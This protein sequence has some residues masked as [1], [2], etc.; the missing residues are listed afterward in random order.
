[1]HVKYVFIIFVCLFNNI[2][3]SKTNKNIIYLSWE[4]VV[5]I[6]LKENLTLKSK[7]L[8]YE[9][10]GLE[11]WKAI[12]SFLPIFSYQGTFIRNLELP[13][14][15]FMG[16]QFVVGTNYSFQH[17]LDLTLPVF[18]GGMRWFNLS[19]QKSLK[20]S[21]SEELKGQKSQT[22]LAALQS[23][24]GIMLSNELMK[25]AKQAVNVA[26][27]NLE[28]VEKHY[29]LGAATELD[30]KRANA[31][32]YSTLP[33]LETATSTR[34]LSYQR[35]KTILNIPLED[36]LVITDSLESENFLE[37]YSSFSLDELKNLALEKRNDLLSLGHK[38]DATGEGEKMALAQF[39]PVIS[40]S[41]N[42]THQAQ[43]D[44]ANI[45]WND[46]IRSKSLI[47]SVY[48][49][50]F[51]GGKKIIDYQLAQ[52]KTEQMKMTLKQAK[53]LASLDI[54][55]KYYSF[56]EV[57]KS[58][59]SLKQAMEESKESMRI[60]SLMYGNGMGTQ[61]D[62]LNAQLLYTKSSAEYLQGIYNYNISQLQLLNAVGLMDKIWK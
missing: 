46:Y 34:L 43:M 59:N 52:I 33:Q 10:Q 1:M 47:L 45:S 49:P 23:Y 6:S 51:E 7:I 60:S 58:L 39:S 21:L 17:S 27:Q 30:L 25:T 53:D 12:S 5:N 4:N 13:V 8:D 50:I 62:V 37:G 54:E 3:F 41:A 42:V 36:S 44:R 55:E 22:V 31:Q 35:L 24:Y 18:T 26:Q 57:L 28:H 9:T 19:A 32:Y 48:W 14:F 40:I 2:L 11:E 16:Q 15:I 29:K 38:L 56:K 20:K 61:L